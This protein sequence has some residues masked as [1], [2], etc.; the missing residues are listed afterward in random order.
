MPTLQ[1]KNFGA[2]QFNADAALE[3]PTGMPGFEERRRFLALH[4][5]G[6]DP[7]VYLQSVEDPGLCFLTIPVLVADP[8]YRLRVEE[9]DAESIGL[10][11]NEPRIGEDV[12]CLTV[13]SL[14]EDGPTANLLAPIVVNLR[15][16]QSVQ[17]VATQSGYSHQHPL[18]A[19]EAVTCS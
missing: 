1:T 4:F 8:S 15:N 19:E 9:E 18:M 7:L 3:F 5:N 10:T 16:R 13:L 2:I 14:R 11:S 12:L 6:T 17:A